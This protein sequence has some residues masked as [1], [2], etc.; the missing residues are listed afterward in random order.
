ML[1]LGSLAK[2]GT[3][4][5]YEVETGKEVANVRQK[6]I[7]GKVYLRIEPKRFLSDNHVK[8]YETWIILLKNKVNAEWDT[9]EKEVV[10]TKIDDKD[11]G[12]AIKR[13]HQK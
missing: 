3:R 8:E 13:F 11:F 1:Y 9:K 4:S 2:D 7:D 10:F 5:I 12:E 6:E